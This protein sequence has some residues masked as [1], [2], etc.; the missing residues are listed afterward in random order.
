MTLIKSSKSPVHL[1]TIK[2][3]AESKDV[4]D[5][6]DWIANL[7][8]LDKDYLK[9]EEWLK[10]D[11]PEL[12]KYMSAFAHQH[13]ALVS[14]EQAQDGHLTLEHI[15]TLYNAYASTHKLFMHDKNYSAFYY[16]LQWIINEHENQ[17][18]YY[19]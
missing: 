2:Q 13:M 5:A 6:I 16:S 7:Q 9:S 8:W 19:Q 1:K 17:N 11:K 15:F 14:Q 3:S 10:R 18:H 4:S 12:A